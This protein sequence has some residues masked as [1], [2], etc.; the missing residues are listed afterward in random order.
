M[1]LLW[2]KLGNKTQDTIVYDQTRKNLK[3]ILHLMLTEKQSLLWG[4]RK[5]SEN[6]SGYEVRITSWSAQ[7]E[8]S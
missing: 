6:I 5:W 8:S 3:C 1:M 7:Q 2:E 4:N